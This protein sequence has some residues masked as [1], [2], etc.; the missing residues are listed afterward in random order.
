M[1]F[2]RPYGNP[3]Q[4]QQE[5]IALV[6]DLPASVE[7]TTGLGR[8]KPDLIVGFQGLTTWVEFKREEKTAAQKR[9]RASQTDW[10][11]TWRGSPVLVVDN[12]MDLVQALITLDMRT[13]TVRANTADRAIVQACLAAAGGLVAGPEDLP[14]LIRKLRGGA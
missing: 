10:L 2:R 1:G 14:A 5:A 13:P 4:G 8:G 3:D 9:L 7:I 11:K 12:G 6:R